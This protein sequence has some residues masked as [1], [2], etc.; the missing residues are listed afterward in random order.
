VE[1]K[2]NDAGIR[3]RK[4]NQV[5]WQGLTLEAIIDKDDPVHPHGR[6]ARVKSVRLL[7]W[8]IRG[9][10]LR[11]ARHPLGAGGHRGISWRC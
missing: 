1:G 3:W 2:H 11:K 5:A 9:K 8:R 6:Q 4:D 7:R 10:P